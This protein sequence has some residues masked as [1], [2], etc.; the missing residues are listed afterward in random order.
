MACEAVLAWEAPP[1][2]ICTESTLKFL[3][4]NLPILALVNKTSTTGRRTAG[5]DCR[6]WGLV[7][8][9]PVKQHHRTSRHQLRTPYRTKNRLAPSRLV[10]GNVSRKQKSG[11]GSCNRRQRY[12]PTLIPWKSNKDSVRLK[13]ALNKNGFQNFQ[14][15]NLSCPG[16]C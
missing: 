2:H 5:L 15:P 13:P 3:S 11:C 7:S 9:Q 4:I 12:Y 14:N 1:N 6:P 16:G 8:R 10:V